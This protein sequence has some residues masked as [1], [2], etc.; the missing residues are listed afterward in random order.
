M[1][2]ITLVTSGCAPESF[3]YGGVE[4][5]EEKYD[6]MAKV[7]K[8]MGD[9]AF[10][11]D[12]FDYSDERANLKIISNLT[13]I[14]E[15]YQKLDPEDE[16]NI[17][18]LLLSSDNNLSIKQ[19]IVNA[20]E[21]ERDFGLLEKQAQYNNISETILLYTTEL[22]GSEKKAKKMTNKFLEDVNLTPSYYEDDLDNKNSNDDNETFD[23]SDKSDEEEKSSS[24]KP[25]SIGESISFSNDSGDKVSVTINSVSKDPGD[26]DYYIP[27]N[28]FFA[29][30]EFTITNIGTEPF[31][32]S[33]HMLEFYD[34]NGMKGTL[35]SREFFSETIQ[36]NKSAS[37]IAYFDVE[38]DTP[39][40]EVFFGNSSW[41]GTY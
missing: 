13:N 38:N 22:I 21:Y 6:Q 1:I 35:D 10:A 33:S 5:E 39:D 18:N 23:S 16:E 12:S 9:V 30:V 20:T 41:T 3:E 26:G 34:G 28:G 25:S 14:E 4:I 17:F 37:G 31:S 19:T 40:F 29:K 11:L 32:A 24:S 2:V 15:A 36:S 7:Y 27:E 8:K